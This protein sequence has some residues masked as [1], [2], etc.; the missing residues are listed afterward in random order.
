MTFTDGDSNVQV[1]QGTPERFFVV[2]ELTADA[3]DQVPNNFLVT[4]R[5]GSSSTAEDRDNDIPLTL[6]FAADAS[7]SL[8]VVATL[9]PSGT[10]VSDSAQGGSTVPGGINFTFAD[11]TGGTFTAQYTT[12]PVSSIQVTISDPGSINFGIPTDPVQLWEINYD[13]TLTDTLTIVFGYEDLNLASGFT[14]S[15]FAIFLFHSGA[16][17]RPSQTIN[18]GNKTITVT[19]SVLSQFVLGADV[20]TSS[21]WDFFGTA[22]GGTVDF[23]VGVVSLQVVTTAGQTPAQVAAAVAAAINGDPTL[24]GEGITATADGNTVTTNGSFTSREINDPGFFDVDPSIPTL[25][26]PGLL[27]FLLLAAAGFVAVRRRRRAASAGSA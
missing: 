14:E 16:W 24:S 20:A 27:L 6:E 21:T 8:V 12:V 11:T 1:A 25:S 4:H 13:E 3:A 10:N 26:G 9:V 22:E 7:S 23:T 2:T 18:T 19:T 5:T 15:Q 17:S